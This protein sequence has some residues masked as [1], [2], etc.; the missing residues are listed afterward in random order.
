MNII[1]VVSDT[2]RRDHLPCYGNNDVI[3]PNINKFAERGLIFEDCRAGSF[4][5]MPARADLFTGRFTFTKFD[6]GPLPLNSRP[7]AQCLSEAEYL[8]CGFV[9][10]PFLI[11]NGYGYDRGFDDFLWIRGQ[12][13]D[14]RQDVVSQRMTEEDYFAPKTFQ[15]AIHWLER[16]YRE[17]NFFLYIDTWDPHEPWDPPEYYVKLYDP[18]YNGEL[19]HPCYW[20]WQEQG[21]SQRDVEIAH[22][23]YCGEITMVDRWFGML[24]DRLEILNLSSSTAIILLSD[25]GFYFGEHGLFGKTRFRW[26]NNIPFVE[27]LLM[28]GL[29]GYQYRS[30]LHNEITQIPLIMHIPEEG[31]QRVQGLCSIPDIMPTILELADVEVPSQVQAPSLIPMIR[32]NNK[33]IHDIVVTSACLENV[34][35]QTKIVDDVSRE[36]NELSPSTITDGEWD[37]LYS[38]YGESVELYNRIEDPGHHLNLVNEFRVKAEELHGKYLKLLLDLKIDKDILEQRLRI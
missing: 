24:L 5:T 31:P 10:T 19:I 34:G 17:K 11:R 14:A 13:G 27:G 28:R 38:V 8:T 30:P 36:V 33:K 15:S 18:T 1:V 2:L 26:E 29:N 16:H 6:W 32:G 12:A 37:L 35:S 4:P 7:L 3:A 20:N 25:H 21:Y 9:D 22:A 23:C